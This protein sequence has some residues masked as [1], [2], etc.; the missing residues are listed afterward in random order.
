ML[1]TWIICSP[2][3]GQQRQRQVAVGNGRLIGA[4][5]AGTLYVDVY[6]LM[7]QRGVGKQVDALLVDLEP[8]RLS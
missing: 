1:F 4:F 7:V 2:H 8:L 6:P 5:L 3:V